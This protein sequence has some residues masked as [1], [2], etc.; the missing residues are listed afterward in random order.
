MAVVSGRLRRAVS[1]VVATVLLTGGV[2]L[3]TAPQAAATTSTADPLS[4]AYIDSA[5]P[6]TS[7]TPEPTG[8]MPVGAFLSGSGL[9]HVSKSYF[10]FDLSA[11]RG[12]TLSSATLF[13]D[14]T[15]ATDCTIP[16]NTTQAWLTAT[17]RKPTWDSQPTEQTQLP[18]SNGLFSCPQGR[19]VW[20]GLAAIQNALAAGRSTMT[21]VLRLPDDE[22]SDPAFGRGFDARVGITFVYNRLPNKPETLAVNGTACASTPLPEGAGTFTL[23]AI[24]TDPD[25]DFLTAQFVYWPVKQPD[26]R[27]EIDES[28]FPDTPPF[29][30]RASF[31]SDNNLTDATTYA[32]QVRGVDAQGPGP[33]SAVCK[34][35][36]DFTAPSVAPTVTSTV[37]PANQS[38]G[39]SGVTGTFTFGA[40]GVKDV[41]GYRY[42]LFGDPVTFVPASTKGGPGT[43]QFTP[44]GIGPIRLTVVSVDAVGNRSPETNYDFFVANNLPTVSCTPRE[45]V[46]GT[47]RQ[48][49]LSPGASTGVVSYNYHVDDGPSA[50]VPAGADGTAT[51]TVTPTTTD[52]AATVFASATLSTGVTTGDSRDFLGVDPAD[53][54]VSQTPDTPFVGQPVTLTFQPVQPGVVS[55]TYQ[56]NQDAPVT[57]PAAADGTATVTV[58]PTSSDGL[59][60]RVFSTDGNGVNSGSTDQFIDVTSNQPTVSSTDY[61]PFTFGG[62]VGVPG[63]FTLSSPLPNVVAYTYTLNSDEP[64]TVA[65]AA[66]PLV[67]TPTTSGEQVLTV[68]STFADGTISEPTTYIFFV[69]STSPA[70]RTAQPM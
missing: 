24:L 58:T 11:F 37:Y 40:N 16:Q 9:T 23:S 33:W 30:T 1:V 2:A 54:L 45:A 14:Q 38:G 65:A 67:L 20:D 29:P 18:G 70:Q 62:G 47:P 13:A 6:H 69:N 34:F 42:G 26:Q 35:S 53:P 39:G 3:L 15:N 66:L 52:G 51:V 31:N 8:D 21:F 36:T 27:V 59:V 17:A 4:A 46:V 48:C 12:A 61:P 49:V 22:Q 28:S 7:L 41:V 25:N 57:V 44:T 43:L 10:T 63:T 64:A 5:V 55:Y 68:T 56:V 32:W 60:V 19:V 50:T